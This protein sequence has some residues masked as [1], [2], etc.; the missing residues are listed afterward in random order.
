MCGERRSDH[1]ARCWIAVSI[2]P[3]NGV[4]SAIKTVKTKLVT[5]KRK[6]GILQLDVDNGTRQ[7]IALGI[8]QHFDLV[9]ASDLAL[10]INRKAHHPHIFMKGGFVHTSLSGR[11]I[12]RIVDHALNKGNIRL[13]RAQR[14]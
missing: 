5:R 7:R 10:K 12:D 6:S 13:D 11:A 4:F 8:L 14:I 9:A 3:F 1:G 2:V